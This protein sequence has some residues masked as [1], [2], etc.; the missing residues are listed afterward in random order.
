MASGDREKRRAK[1]SGSMWLH[2]CRV[3]PENGGEE[4]E[5]PVVTMASLRHV[6]EYDAGPA[7]PMLVAFVPR[8]ADYITS[9]GLVF[10]QQRNGLLARE[11]IGRAE[12]HKRGERT[13]SRAPCAALEAIKLQRCAASSSFRRVAD[14]G[15]NMGEAR[16]QIGCL[17]TDTSAFMRETWK[18]RIIS[19][20]A[21]VVRTNSVVR[22]NEGIL[23]N[24]G[25]L[26][27]SWRPADLLSADG[28]ME[29]ILVMYMYRK[30]ERAVDHDYNI[31]RA[32][33]LS[34]YS[35][36]AM[37]MF[38]VKTG[39]V[40]SQNDMSRELMGDFELT[41]V[42]RDRAADELSGR[43]PLDDVHD[44]LKRLF[45]SDETAYHELVQ[46]VRGARSY[47]CRLQTTLADLRGRAAPRSADDAQPI[48]LEVQ[49]NPGLDPVTGV[50]VIVVT[51]TDVSQIVKL[52]QSMQRAAE[53]ER[54]SQRQ[55]ISM[56]FPKPVVQELLASVVDNENGG[57]DAPSPG[58]R[59][60]EKRNT[61]NRWDS[62]RAA[63][64]GASKEGDEAIL[65]G[66]GG[67]GGGG[68]RSAND[69]LG[70]N[71]LKISAFGSTDDSSSSSPSSSS[72]RFSLGN[73]L[74]KKAKVT[75]RFHRNVSIIFTDIVG[76][77]SESER[78][79]P[80]QV[81]ALLDELFSRFDDIAETHGVYKVETIGDAYMGCS[82]LRDDCKAGD[83]CKGCDGDDTDDDSQMNAKQ[84]V[85]FALNCI[86]AVE[87]MRW[88]S[89][90][91]VR[92]R[93]GVHSGDVMSGIIGKT[94]PRYALYGDTV[95]TASRMEST[96][97]AMHLQ[98]SETTFAMLY[99]TH[100]AGKFRWRETTKDVKGKGSSIKTYVSAP[101]HHES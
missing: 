29:R 66:S 97:E 69:T 7:A 85:S 70:T 81:M 5:V 30:E 67:G 43:N 96:G 76:F 100:D 34:R 72:R 75:A 3:E 68:R 40:L 26:R 8:P 90:A 23:G 101:H 78:S 16:S 73:V 80:R 25:F 22:E 10:L 79:T 18:E 19:A 12:A 60:P 33:Y 61:L 63:L 98:V 17:Y 87:T 6:I 37:T 45:R 50:K 48:W 47:R 94:M 42:N 32:L 99:N 35:T 52:E 95:N 56:L 46:A 2:L 62:L 83:D 49:A 14:E 11:R 88:P 13:T 92:I 71:A 15:G 57:D 58:P 77:T 82:G 74:S 51:A 1:D 59:P 86:S 20:W 65:D 27:M 38:D 41:N 44:F 91:P 93:A 54:A 24:G 9:C 31:A 55:L 64:S 39:E 28:S 53:R 36:A 84:A 21:Q 89:G 4:E